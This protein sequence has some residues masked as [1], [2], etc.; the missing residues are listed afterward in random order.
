MGFPGLWK[1]LGGIS[2]SS[3]NPKA[4]L[5]P[6]LYNSTYQG[7]E[8]PCVTPTDV[9]KHLFQVFD[10]VFPQNV[11]PP[12]SITITII[13]YPIR[14][15]WGRKHSFGL[16]FQVIIHDCGKA[17]GEST[18]W[19]WTECPHSRVELAFSSINLLRTCLLR[20]NVTYTNSYSN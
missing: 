1:L 5:K 19:M 15:N 7:H 6:W 8:K 3:L 20:K 14:K 2:H 17:S 10:T 16:Q 18:D 4:A 9:D 11:P 12:T 13:K